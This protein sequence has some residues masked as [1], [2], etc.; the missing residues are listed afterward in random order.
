MP[1][2]GVLDAAFVWRIDRTNRLQVNL[3]NFL[4]NGGFT[5]GGYTG[6]IGCGSTSTKAPGTASD[7]MIFNPGASLLVTFKHR[8]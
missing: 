4:Y 5:T 1:Q 6:I 3:Y 8:V 7:L 2:Y